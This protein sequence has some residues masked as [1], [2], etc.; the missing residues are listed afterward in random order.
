MQFLY[1]NKMANHL[2]KE[3]M[4]KINTIYVL[5]HP[6]DFIIKTTGKL[7]TQ[8]QQRDEMN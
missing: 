5:Q 4:M 1:D 7:T 8:K 2:F 3:E 6:Y